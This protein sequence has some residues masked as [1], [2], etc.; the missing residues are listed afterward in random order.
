[1]ASGRDAK[2]SGS[3]DLRWELR[4]A[5]GEHVLEFAHNTLS[6]SRTARLDGAVVYHTVRITRSLARVDAL[7]IVH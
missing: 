7:S 3:G 2:V 6:G 5:D 4:L 1:M